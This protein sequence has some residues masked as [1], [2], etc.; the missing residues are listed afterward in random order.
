MLMPSLGMLRGGE[1]LGGGGE[2]AW[3]HIPPVIWS[4]GT[5]LFIQLSC[6]CLVGGR[7]GVEGG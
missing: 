5:G 4:A 2:G 7:G 1:G 3:L 6:V